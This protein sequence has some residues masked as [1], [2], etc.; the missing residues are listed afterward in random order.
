MTS[1]YGGNSQTILAKKTTKHI[2]ISSNKICCDKINTVK[3]IAVLFDLDKP[4]CLMQ[5]QNFLF[6][7]SE[8]G[9]LWDYFNYRIDEA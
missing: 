3:S 6:L 9:K 1:I 5:S 7:V 2:C 4:R 8:F